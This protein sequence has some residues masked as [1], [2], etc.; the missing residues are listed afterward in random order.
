M[1]PLWFEY[2]MDESTYL[3]EDQ[4]LVGRD[5]LVAPV[6]SQGATSRNVYF[7]DGDQ[8][9][10]WWTGD[11]YEGGTETGIDAPIQTLPLFVRLGSAIP[12]QPIVQHTGE[13]AHAPLGV[14]AAVGSV[15]SNSSFYED[16]G[17]GF[18]YQTGNFSVVEI[19]QEKCIL[20]FKR[21]GAF[22]SH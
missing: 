10:S 7:P 5:L 9:V 2:P 22:N 17:D 19:S 12:I 13:M 4:F 18:D 16:A 20:C 15:S 1:R 3:I 11:H 6:V 8:W 21:S 14:A